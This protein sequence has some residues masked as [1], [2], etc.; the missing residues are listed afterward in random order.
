MS[1]TYELTQFENSQG[2]LSNL[3]EQGGGLLDVFSQGLTDIWQGSVTAA[4]D[5]V[6]QSLF[7]ATTGDN[8]TQ[9]MGAVEADQNVQAANSAVPMTTTTTSIF[10]LTPAQIMLFGA[11][12]VLVLALKK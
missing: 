3:T 6:N 4:G 7:G 1:S 5:W 9:L 8:Q 2:L 10:G 12:V 11:G